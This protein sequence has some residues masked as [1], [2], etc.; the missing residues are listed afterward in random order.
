MAGH[1]KNRAV[2]MSNNVFSRASKQDMLETGCSMSRSDDE[3]RSATPGAITDLLTGMTSL[4]RCFNLKAA[5]IGF[6]NQI[7]HLFASRLLGVLRKSR[8]VVSRILV[9]RD[10]VLEVNRIQQD[11]LGFKLVREVLGV[12]QSFIEHSEKSI[13]TSILRN[14]KAPR[15]NSPGPA[16][17]R[18]P[19]RITST[20]QGE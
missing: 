17:S 18:S 6:F 11:K 10:V 9:A 4:Q 19:P 2:R 7:A 12:Q 8:Q 3:V 20:G 14:P 1:H 16:F 15:E 13:G 5:P